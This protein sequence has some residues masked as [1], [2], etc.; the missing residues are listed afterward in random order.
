MKAFYYA[1]GE[2]VEANS[3]MGELS[4]DKVMRGAMYMDVWVPKVIHSLTRW[5]C[6]T[7]KDKPVWIGSRP[8]MGVPAGRTT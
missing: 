8:P 3:A 4:G 2:Y 5:C 7:G 6:S 1:G